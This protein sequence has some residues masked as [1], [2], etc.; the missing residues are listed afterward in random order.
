MRR[1]RKIYFLG[2]LAFILVTGCLMPWVF[3]SK[4]AKLRDEDHI[5]P[6]NLVGGVA[7]ATPNLPTVKMIVKEK[8]E[9]FAATSKK[10]EDYSSAT[11]NSRHP[12]ILPEAFNNSSLVLHFIVSSGC[13]EYQQWEVLSQIHSARSV[14]QHG[15][16]T[17][18]VSGCLLSEQQEA[19]AKKGGKDQNTMTPSQIQIALGTHFPESQSNKL[20]TPNVHFTPDYSD[21]AVY[22]GPFADGKKKR[23]FLSKGN[24]TQHSNFGNHYHFNN[25][26]NGLLHWALEYYSVPERLQE[27]EAVV[28]IDP[29][30][31]FLKLFEFADN[32]DD[33]PI[34]GRPSAAYY[35]LGGQWL[36][37]NR[38]AICGSGSRCTKVVGRE[39]KYY[40]VGPPYL[41]HAQDVINLTKYWSAFVPPTY[42][43]YPLLY[44][45]MYA[46]SMAAAHL[47]MPHKTIK[48]I[49]MGCMLPWPKEKLTGDPGPSAKAFIQAGA[50][51]ENPDRDGGPHSCFQKSLNTPPF[52][53]YCARYAFHLPPQSGTYYFFAKRKVPSEILDCDS[54]DLKLFLSP[55][56]KERIDGHNE[57]WTTLTACAVL[58]AVN[59][60]RKHHCGNE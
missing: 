44:A 16:Y 20:I 43:Q 2:L 53:H 8:I 26:P 24:K 17:W 28:L 60:A 3:V 49:Y 23:T 46:Y 54:E 48:D 25:K 14:G 30:F 50:D 4:L 5:S 12:L 58:R 36:D 39:V 11:K 13:S 51:L 59:F 31:L 10:N 27:N 6:H 9:P 7:A 32:D 38:T 35:G 18:I 40:S 34:P 52:L 47:N 22:G 1:R 57:N 33:S 56:E 37:F 42:D 15:R 41:I 19:A 21:M 55:N 29:D 45:E